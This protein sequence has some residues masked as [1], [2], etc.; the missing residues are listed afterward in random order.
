MLAKAQ[1]DLKEALR[2][3]NDAVAIDEASVKAGGQGAGVLPTFLS[4]RSEI[5]MQAGQPDKA[6]A[7]AVRALDLSEAA[8]HPGIFSCYTGRAYFAL[9]RALQAQ[10]RTDEARSAFRSAAEHLENTLGTEN[11]ESRAARQLAGS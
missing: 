10:R 7:D 9:G 11:V 6:A 8:A 4:R 1:G 5:E 2:L 3:A